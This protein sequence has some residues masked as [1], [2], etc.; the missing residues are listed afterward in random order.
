M[1]AAL[2][3]WTLVGYW[4]VKDPRSLTGRACRAWLGLVVVDVGLLFLAPTSIGGGTLLT[5]RQAV[6]TVFAVI[7]LMASQPHRLARASLVAGVT[8][9]LTL[10]IHASRWTF[11]GAY[12]T[13]VRELVAGAPHSLAG[14]T[15]FATSV[16]TERQPEGAAWPTR[17]AAAYVAVARG[18]VLVNHYELLTT[19]F[20]LVARRTAGS[21]LTLRAQA[22]HPPDVVLVWGSSLDELTRAGSQLLEDGSREC[23][24]AIAT[25]GQ[26]RWLSCE[27][28]SQPGFALP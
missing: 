20:P 9:C 7:L 22:E 12:D 21:G 25:V 1:L 6:F 2:A 5:P 19:H 4:L 16:D 18:A 11:Y 15:L 23:S 24:V 14:R 17:H 10:S 26:A 27:R 13:A 8:L 3:L 28:A